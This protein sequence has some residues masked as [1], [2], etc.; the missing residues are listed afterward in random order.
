[1]FGFINNI[2]VF[3]LYILFIYLY[4]IKTTM[5]EANAAI[6][7]EFLSVI[8]RRFV[9]Y[10]TYLSIVL[11]WYRFGAGVVTA[12]VYIGN[13]SRLYCEDIYSIFQ[14][15]KLLSTITLEIF[16]HL[17][18]SVKFLWY[19]FSSENFLISCS[20]EHRAK[21]NVPVVPGY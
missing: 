19:R 1:M 2:E 12:R 18:L 14:N 20:N 8:S 6:F 17:S 10:N 13:R 3:T 9:Y 21:T 7:R 4:I 16:I 5:P 15:L 11:V